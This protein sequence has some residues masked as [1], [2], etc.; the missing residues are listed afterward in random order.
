MRPRFRSL[1]PPLIT[2]LV[3]SAGGAGC[4]TQASRERARLAEADA[5]RRA[6]TEPPTQEVLGQIREAA[7]AFM[8]ERHGEQQVEAWTFTSLTPNLFLV[9]VSVRD[10]GGATAVRQLSA[11]RLRDEEPSWLSGELQ[12]N[13]ELVWV[14]DDL[15]ELKMKLLASRHGLEPE[16]DQIRGE[17]SGY[18][19]VHSW[20]RRTWLDD[21]LLWHYLYHRP[22]PVF[23]SPGGG[24]QAQPMGYRFQDPA[25]ARIQPEDARPYEA[26]AARTGGRS[27]VFL[28]GGAWH[29]PLASTT[30]GSQGLGYHVSGG[31]GGAARPGFFGS[32]FRGGSGSRGGSVSRGGAFA[33]GGFGAAGRAAGGHFGG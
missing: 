13:G 24:Y 16:V 14:I 8:K 9:G 10:P 11:E 7:A 5:R 6:E 19:H 33:R 28:G 18:T 2:I 15:D 32:L 27:A 1:T 25:G 12:E 21:Y 3:L 17:D 31:G 30:V 20:G 26:G 23:Y 22:P 4:E 29:P